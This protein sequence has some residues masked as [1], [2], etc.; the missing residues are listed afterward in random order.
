[1]TLNVG[2]L[3]FCGFLYWKGRRYPLTSDAVYTGH[4][5]FDFFQGIELHPTLL[6]VNLKQLIN[7]R[8][9]MMGW[10]VLL[11]CSRR[12]QQETY[13]LLSATRCWSRS[14]LSGRLSLQVLLVGERL[15]QLAR[16]HAR[17]L[18]LLHLLGRPGLGAGASTRLHAQYLANIPARLHPARAAAIAGVGLVAL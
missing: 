10:S 16:H 1:M 5:L 6:G 12:H 11:V 4:A 2:A 14:A 7:C 3:A 18:R 13:G 8:V 9:S 17:P 15:L